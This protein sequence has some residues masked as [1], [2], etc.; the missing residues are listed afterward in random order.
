[1]GRVLSFITT[2]SGLIIFAIVSTMAIVRG[3][4]IGPNIGYTCVSIIGIG[5]IG[6][7]F[8]KLAERK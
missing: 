6:K 8:S 4:D 2:I 5:V 3:G 1:M 7:G